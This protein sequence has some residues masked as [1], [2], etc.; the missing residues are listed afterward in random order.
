[1]RK[2][3]RRHDRNRSLGRP[4]HNAVVMLPI[5][6]KVTSRDQLGLKV[7]LTARHS[8]VMMSSCRKTVRLGVRQRWKRTS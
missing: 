4:R 3:W 8:D 6:V 7:R 2:R 5:H 1:L